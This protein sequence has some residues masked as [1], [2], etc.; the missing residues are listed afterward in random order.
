MLMWAW[1]HH[2]REMSCQRGAFKTSTLRH[3]GMRGGIFGGGVGGQGLNYKQ[4]IF[5]KQIWFLTIISASLTGTEGSPGTL[6]WWTLIGQFVLS[7][8]RLRG[9]KSCSVEGLSAGAHQTPTVHRRT[10]VTV[11]RKQ[12]PFHRNITLAFDFRKVKGCQL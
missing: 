11:Q 4:H 6:N 2:G 3:S 5:Y 7:Y 1:C 12:N 9:G 10:L 8:S